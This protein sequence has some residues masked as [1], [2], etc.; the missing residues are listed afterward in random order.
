MK[1]LNKVGII[2]WH[3]YSNFGSSLQ[4]YSLQTIIASIGYDVRI[5]NYHNPHFGKTSQ[6]FNLIKL[7]ISSTVGK[8][9]FKFANKFSSGRLEFEYKYLR[10]GRL[11]QSIDELPNLTSDYYALV[12]GSDQIWAPNCFDPI[13]FAA[14]ANK[15]IRKI[16][17]AASI[18]LSEIPEKLVS[19]Y[20]EYLSDF[21][22]IGIREQEGK[23]LL[24]TQ[25]GIDSKVVLDPTFLLKESDYEKIERKVKNCKKDGYLLVYL[26]NEN[27]Q[28]KEHIIAYA[29]KHSL[30]IIGYST[31]SGDKHWMQQ[32]PNLGADQFIWLI[33]NS[34]AVMTD[35]Y[36]GTIFS[37]LFHKNFYTFL[38][39]AE[40]DPIN[41]NSRIRQLQDYFG[42]QGHIIGPKD[43]IDETKP[44]EY[45]AFEAKLNDL[46]KNSIDFLKI[47]LQ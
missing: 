41:Q 11:T 2:T 7:I 13:Y 8:L 14:F 1:K 40:G 28:Y 10:C 34:A 42:L 36:H 30:R 9:P 12:C 47:A 22:A 43:G 19:K 23:M 45:E 26:L 33:H 46:R 29:K 4:A 25:C 3:Y 32:L 38:R 44:I 6:I 5:V 15:G 16:S 37:L 35:S 24:N 18:G 39:F 31:K 21:Y 20:K 17:Y 27:H